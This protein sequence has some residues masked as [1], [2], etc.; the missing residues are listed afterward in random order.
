MKQSIRR[1]AA[2]FALLCCGCAFAAPY[3]TEGQL[4]T[5]IA[6]AAKILKTEGVELKMFDAQKFGMT[7]PLLAESLNLE[8]GVCEVFFNTKPEYGLIQ[9]FETIAE[10]DLPLLLNAMAMHE[11]AHCVEQRE[12]VLRALQMTPSKKSTKGKP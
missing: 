12:A 7:Q 8:S 1:A 10:N 2:A 4:R 11:A 9:Y 3:P 5:A 6:N